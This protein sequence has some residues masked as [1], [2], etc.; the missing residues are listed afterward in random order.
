MK[1]I[2]HFGMKVNRRKWE[3]RRCIITELIY[4]D[5]IQKVTRINSARKDVNIHDMK[6]GPNNKERE[7]RINYGPV[8]RI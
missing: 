3:G 8:G 4:Y 2:S 1:L 5:N 6:D 7:K